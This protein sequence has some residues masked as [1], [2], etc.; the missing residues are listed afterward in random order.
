MN[1]AVNYDGDHF[2]GV[3]VASV[4]QI[5]SKVVAARNTVRPPS[6]RALTR[7]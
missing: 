7:P 4:L 2:V 6:G 5:D 1:W 3:P